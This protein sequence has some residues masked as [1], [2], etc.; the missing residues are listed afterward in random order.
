MSPSDKS[1]SQSKATQSKANEQKTG[2]S[3]VTGP[4]LTH[5]A[6]SND[7]PQGGGEAEAP[8]AEASKTDTP[9]TQAGMSQDEPWLVSGPPDPAQTTPPPDAPSQLDPAAA[10]SQASNPTQDAITQDV[11]EQKGESVETPSSEGSPSAPSALEGTPPEGSQPEG[12]TADG[13]P[14]LIGPETRGPI[15]A[16]SSRGFWYKALN[17]GSAQPDFILQSGS[18][19]SGHKVLAILDA[20]GNEVWSVNIVGAAVTN[21]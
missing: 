4:S 17:N 12:E 16:H 18:R 11:L 13:Q 20:D 5:G 9:V 21:T 14:L 7:P 6:G 19:Q 1:D 10:S 8:T 15:V 3:A 2:G